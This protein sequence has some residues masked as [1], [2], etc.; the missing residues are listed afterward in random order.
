[1]IRASR[2]CCLILMALAG[3]AWAA[4]QE[5]PAPLANV[6]ET[7]AKKL[8]EALGEGQKILIIDVRSPADYAAGHVPG[9]VNIPFVDFSK[10]FAELRVAKDTTVVTICDHGGRSSRAALELRK[11]GYQTSSFCTLD[12]W[13]KQGYKIE[14]GAQKPGRSS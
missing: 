4:P 13:K 10:K 11:L 8:Q 7:T 9:A 1:M 6:P 5:H 3:A 12:S 14:T 2:T